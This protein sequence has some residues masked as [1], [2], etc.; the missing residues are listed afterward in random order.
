[1]LFLGSASKLEQ[2]AIPHKT[3]RSI[4]STNLSD[5]FDLAIN[6]QPLHRVRNDV[7]AIRPFGRNPDPAIASGLET[8][9]SESTKK[10]S[11]F[12]RFLLVEPNRFF[13][14][15]MMNG[16]RRVRRSTDVVTMR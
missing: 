13:T 11:M 6:R 14:I 5:L 2:K 16:N 3:R 12:R 8:E 10:L 9:S 4:P 7:F 1:M 15:G